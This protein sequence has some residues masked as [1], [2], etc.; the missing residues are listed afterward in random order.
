MRGLVAKGL[1]EEQGKDRGVEGLGKDC[2]SDR[3][4]YERDYGRD[5]E[6]D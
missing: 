5:W 3:K 2:E 4:G 1:E 6:R